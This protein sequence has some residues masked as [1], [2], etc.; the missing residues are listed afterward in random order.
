MDNGAKCFASAFVSG[1]TSLLSQENDPSSMTKRPQNTILKFSWGTTYYST[2]YIGPEW[3]FGAI[4][5]Q[6]TQGEF[7]LGMRLHA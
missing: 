2:N 7:E 6:A 4:S 5:S 1:H 3:P